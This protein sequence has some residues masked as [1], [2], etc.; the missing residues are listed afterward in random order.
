M[1]VKQKDSSGAFTK[2][3][4]PFSVTSNTLRGM[5]ELR[6]LLESS[7]AYWAA[8]R[9]DETDILSIRNAID[10]LREDKNLIYDDDKARLRSV[11]L[12]SHNMHKSIVKASKNMVL[13]SVYES[14]YELIYIAQNLTIELPGIPFDTILAYEAIWH[15]I[16]ERD[17][18]GAR[19]CM[20]EH[21]EGVKEKLFK[22]LQEEDESE[23]E[24]GV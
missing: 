4:F 23:P 13:F 12:L 14:L 7:G 20:G 21:M 10:R 9:R 18:E 11:R 8:L 1:Y 6:C 2:M 17:C 3:S 24:P 5:M 16:V 22:K 15:K 19:S